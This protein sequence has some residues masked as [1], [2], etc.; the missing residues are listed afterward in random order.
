MDV[1]PLVP[2]GLKLIDGYG[3]GFFRIGGERCTG[4]LLLTARSV[5]EL[6]AVEVAAFDA[7]ALEALLAPLS[8]VEVLLVGQGPLFVGPAPKSWR[9]VAAAHHIV[10]ET[11]DSKA[12]CRTWNVLLAEGRAIAALLWPL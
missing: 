7:A 11:M 8:G 4:P 6:A 3:P 9:E 2:A 1:T 5:T 12:A 10:L